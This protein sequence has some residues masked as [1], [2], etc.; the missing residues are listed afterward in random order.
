MLAPRAQTNRARKLIGLFTYTQGAH[1]QLKLCNGRSRKR[2]F[3]NENGQPT[4]AH[5]SNLFFRSF[6]WQDKI[7][8]SWATRSI[9]R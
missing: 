9:N 4:L 5:T 1:G 8:E 2:A 6:E 7:K 3:F